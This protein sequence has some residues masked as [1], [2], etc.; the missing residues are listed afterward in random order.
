LG[1]FCPDLEVYSIDEAFLNLEGLKHLDLTQYAQEIRQKVKMWTGIPVSIGIA[2]TKTLSK[3]AN[4][5]AKK[6]KREGVFYLE[7]Q[8]IDLAL[9]HLP[10]EEIW[11][12][13]RRWGKRLNV[14]GIY[15]ALDLKNADVKKMRKIFSVVM[16][17]M[18]LELRGISCLDLEDTNPKKSIMVS[19]SFRDPIETQEGIEEAINNFAV[20][21]AEKLRGEGSKA[22]S[23]Y[24][25]F[26]TSSFGDAIYVRCEKFMT[27]SKPTSDTNIILKAAKGGVGEVFKKGLKYKKAGVLLLVFGMIHK[28]TYF[29]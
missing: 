25:F 17:R 2:S 26:R 14:L 24:I 10:V 11:E 6:Q 18:I 20:K 4:H 19:R 13:G 28:R 5:I 8:N 9:K 16:E 1:V 7:D 27:F 21:A 12:V 3:V 29:S 15:T 22:H 23:L